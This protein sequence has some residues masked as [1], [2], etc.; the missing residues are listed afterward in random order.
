LYTTAY[1]HWYA[2]NES[3]ERANLMTTLAYVVPPQIAICWM[4]SGNP[5]EQS[6]YLKLCQQPQPITKYFVGASKFAL[7]MRMM[8]WGKCFTQRQESNE[9]KIFSAASAADQKVLVSVFNSTLYFWYWELIGDGWHITSKELDNFF[10]NM[11]TLS[12]TNRSVLVKLCE[13]LM[14]DLDKKKVFVGTKQTEYEY[15]HRLSKPIIDEIDRVL[16]QHYGFTDE[17]L[18]FIINYDI[19][20]RM[21]REAEEAE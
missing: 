18:D 4:K 10:F 1:K 7:N 8:Y 5:I 9:Y 2:K 14:V 3:D 6:I 20:Y 21:G 15:Y 12:T 11:E 19:K 17:E 13:D 16:A